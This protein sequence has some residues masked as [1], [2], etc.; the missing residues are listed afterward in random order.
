MAAPDSDSKPRY[1][2]DDGRELELLK[3]IFSLPD[4]EKRLRNNPAAILDEIDKFSTTNSHLIHVGPEKGAIVTSLIADQKPSVMVELGGYVGYSAIL[5][6]DAVR[7]AGGEKY[8]SLE[9]NPVNAAIANLLID[10]AGLRDF[11]SIV[12]AP[13][14]LSLAGLLE[15]GVL[16]DEIDVLFI[17]HW[18]DRYLPDIWLV[19]AL[20]LLKPGKSIIVADNILRRGPSEFEYIAWVQASPGEKQAILRGHT[21]KTPTGIDIRNIVIKDGVEG[22]ESAGIDL[23]LVPGNPELVYEP[24]TKYHTGRD[25]AKG[26]DLGI[27]I[28][29]A[30]H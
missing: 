25:D 1:R 12:I 20:G 7:R 19:E 14:H 2:S 18:K 15:K 23:E 11:I 24:V 27:H 17:D 8:I 4:L 9:L 26:K 22:A 6:G 29:T 21:F 30:N 5:F 10:L 3:H 13:A 28:L 16:K